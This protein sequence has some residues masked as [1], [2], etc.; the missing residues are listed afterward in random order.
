MKKIIILFLTLFFICLNFKFEV[1]AS[2]QHYSQFEDQ[3]VVEPTEEEF[4]PFTEAMDFFNS[5]VPEDSFEIENSFY[6]KNYNMLGDYNQYGTCTLVSLAYLLGYYDTF[7]NGTIVPNKLN[8]LSGDDIN[9]T[10]DPL[11]SKVYTGDFAYK[12][13]VSDNVN[14]L[15]PPAPTKEFHDYLVD[16]ALIN[17]IISIEEVNYSDGS[18]VLSCGGIN[19]YKMN[20]ILTK[21]LEE[22]NVS[23]SLLTLNQSSSN[24][25]KNDIL[26][27]LDKN[28]PLRLSVR[29][30]TYYRLYDNYIL[31]KK[32]SNY[33]HSIVAYGYIANEQ[34]IYL[35]ANFGN[36][37]DAEYYVK[38]DDVVEYSYYSING[39]HVCSDNYHYSYNFNGETIKVDMCPCNDYNYYFTH[40]GL[41]TD[42]YGNE[43]HNFTY[44]YIQNSLIQ[45]PHSMTNYS[46]QSS[47]SHTANCKFY[48]YCGECENLSHNS[49]IMTNY[50]R[51]IGGEDSEVNGSGHYIYCEDCGYINFI[52]H[53]FEV[54]QSTNICSFS[55]SDCDYD[56]VKFHNYVIEGKGLE[57]VKICKYCGFD[58]H[59]LYNYN[60]TCTLE[61]ENTHIFDCSCGYY[62][63][64]SHCYDGGHCINCSFVHTNHIAHEYN[65]IGKTS[66]SVDCFCGYSTVER[67]DFIHSGIGMRCKYCG[68]FTKDPI[69]V[70]NVPIENDVMGNSNSNRKEGEDD[71]E[72]TN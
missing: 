24:F 11:F 64:L 3:N 44:N 25:D 1:L 29:D 49:Y 26:E 66:H 48:E 16:I 47:N 35:K 27:L 63:E 33:Y 15:N 40:T 21:Y 59:N 38:L 50:I 10:F 39:S 45:I 56:I 36:S 46:F 69:I 12:T 37:G 72:Q 30:C 58:Y 19:T 22:I 51:F 20:L 28:I 9:K 32:T 70:V 6:F 13:W 71:Y 61:D 67:H 62:E 4:I 54:T 31:G 34:G 14:D 60:L 7:D 53:D 5:L 17:N 8:Y 23:T 68:Y 65:S 42:S 2:D 52:L 41:T 43:V 57:H 18:C 55:C